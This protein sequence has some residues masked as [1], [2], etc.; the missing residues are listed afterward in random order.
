MIRILVQND[1]AEQIRQSEGQV[2][3]V[4]HQGRCVGIVRRPPTEQEIQFAKVRAGSPGRRFTVDE[5][6]AQV[7]A[8]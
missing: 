4:D 7:E 6:I 2:E 5:L 8:F 3:L 1:V